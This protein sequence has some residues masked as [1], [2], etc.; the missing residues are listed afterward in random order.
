MA[1]SA[2]WT[3]HCTLR[4]FSGMLKP[5]YEAGWH[6]T[7][8]P[9]LL[10]IFR[11]W[12]LAFNGSGNYQHSNRS[13]SIHLLQGQPHTICDQ[14]NIYPTGAAILNSSRLLR[15][16]KSVLYYSL[17]L[18]SQKENAKQYHR[19]VNNQI[20]LPLLRWGDNS[21]IKLLRPLSPYQSP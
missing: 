14:V 7:G 13:I 3:R 17:N 12:R 2:H 21:H 16:P 9:M 10:V 19:V 6:F 18:P 15:E 4:R 11:W 20:Y 5:G 8:R 1:H